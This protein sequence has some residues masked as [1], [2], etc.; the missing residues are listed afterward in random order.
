MPDC[1][2][3]EL[4]WGLYRIRTMCDYPG[5]SEVL[6][7]CDEYAR[8]QNKVCELTYQDRNQRAEINELRGE[9]KWLRAEL[10][11]ARHTDEM[12]RRAT[13]LSKLRSGDA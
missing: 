10:E 3:D 7:L 2:T 8:L 5:M 9:V 4:K 11:K 6:A 13:R 12:E 1:D